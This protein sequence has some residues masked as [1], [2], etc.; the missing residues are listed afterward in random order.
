MMWF[1]DQMLSIETPFG[2][3][4]V[5]VTGEALHVWWGAGVG[6][7]DAAGLMRANGELI[8][9]LATIKREAGEVGDNG[10]ISISE[11]DVED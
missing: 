3:T 11:I 4:D 5:C 6:P 10:L 9:H 8:T 7:Q 2:P 1:A